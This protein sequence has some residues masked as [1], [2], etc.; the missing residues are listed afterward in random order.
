MGPT[1][2]KI[3]ALASG[4]SPCS[5]S[6]LSRLIPHSRHATVIGFSA[7]TLLMLASPVR[8]GLIGIHQWLV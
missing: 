4:T 6:K 2:G 3:T 8:G 5:E 1:N 7:M